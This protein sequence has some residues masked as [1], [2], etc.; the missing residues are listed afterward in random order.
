MIFSTRELI[1]T[2]GL[3]KSDI[4][5]QLRTGRL[6][7]VKRGWYQQDAPASPT[8]RH[9]ALVQATA[10]DLSPETVISHVS[11]A[12]MHG[13]PV[14]YSTLE[15]VWVTRRGGGHGGNSAGLRVSQAPL[16]DGDIV[17]VD[18]IAATA[19]ERTVLDVARTVPH[20]WGVAAVDAFLR[21][22]GTAQAQD[23]LAERLADESR[24]RGNTRARSA[25]GFAS[26]LAESPGESISRAIFA[27]AR[28]PTP[29]L[30]RKIVLSDGRL[31]FGDF[32]W[33]A[34][35]TVGEF[36]GAI[37]YS[38]DQGYGRSP[39]EAFIA[40]KTREQKLRDVGWWF[41]RWGWNDL[42]H[43]DALVARIRRAFEFAPRI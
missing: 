17:L 15:C 14:P 40:E 18:G 30:Q 1:E 34:Q 42:S 32:A 2:H 8:E 29:V 28:L 41:V 6:A 38:R 13:I 25:V 26:P 16:T 27:Q 9:S 21:L 37:K 20:K 4:R 43:P 35:R 24:R 39:E 33:E 23:A 12:V 11:A 5:R 19:L 7:S 36:D 22:D 3:G 10:N 31:A